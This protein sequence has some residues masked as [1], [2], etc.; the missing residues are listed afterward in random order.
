[1]RR[2]LVLPLTGTG[3]DDDPIRPDLGNATDEV[4]GWAMAGS[5]GT[6]AL[7]LV[8]RYQSR[9]TL[10]PHVPDR[11]REAVGDE[12]VDEMNRRVRIPEHV[13]SELVTK[14]QGLGIP[15]GWLPEQVDVNLGAG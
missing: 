2:W 15:A 3:T 5:D 8:V 1:M 12:E 10:P 6:E 7:V 4:D 11:A 13:R 9:P 14:A